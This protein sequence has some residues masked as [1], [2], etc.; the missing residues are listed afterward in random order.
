MTNLI[1]KP[2]ESDSEEAALC[3][4]A[5][6]AFNFSEDRWEKFPQIV[7]RENIRVAINNDK[8]VGGM[9]FY[10][11]AQWFGGQSMPMAAI[12]LVLTGVEH[13]GKGFANGMLKTVME[14]L[15]NSGCPL[16]TLYPSTQPVYRKLGFEQAG[17]NYTYTTKLS[18]IRG[19]QKKCAVRRADL[20]TDRQLLQ[21]LAS[22]YASANN[23]CLERNDGMWKRLFR[24]IHGKVYIY[25]MGESGDERGYLIYD[26][27]PDRII[28][29]RDM[30]ALDGDAQQTVWSVIASNRSIMEAVR[31]TGPSND[32]RGLCIQEHRSRVEFPRRWMLRLLDVRD[33]LL[34]RGYPKL[35]G[36]LTLEV[37]DDLFAENTGNF[38][39][40]L[41]RGTPN[42]EQSVVSS[43]LRITVHDLAPLYSG[44]WTATQLRDAG[45]LTCDDEDTIELANQFFAGSEPWMSD[46]F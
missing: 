34:R 7:G 12:A 27:S 18:D 11:V 9:S 25:V 13:R 19:V 40:S 28:E 41:E 35:T 17:N 46:A 4:L 30:V 38:T 2:M 23:G 37:A 3:D 8:V 39:L 6:Q 45:R 21:T 14:E 10:P 16:A 43:P 42:V 24:D 15:R 32:L 44:L 22:K 5:T 29:V 26:Q 33:A 20:E 1:V 31:W 36:Q